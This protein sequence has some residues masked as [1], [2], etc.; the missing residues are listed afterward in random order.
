MSLSRVVIV[1]GFAVFFSAIPDASCAVFLRARPSK[2]PL[3]KTLPTANTSSTPPD[4]VESGNSNKKQSELEAAD[5]LSNDPFASNLVGQ[6]DDFAEDN[7]AERGA[8]NKQVENAPHGKAQRYSEPEIEKQPPRRGTYNYITGEFKPT[9]AA[10]IQ[11]HE[12][13]SDDNV[14][15]YT[16]ESWV[17]SAKY[18]DDDDDD[19]D[20][21][22]DDDNSE[23]EEDA[24]EDEADDEIKL[25]TAQVATLGK[26]KVV[27]DEFADDGSD[28]AR[29][30]KVRESTDHTIKDDAEDSENGEDSSARDERYLQQLSATLDS[31]DHMKPW[32]E[33]EK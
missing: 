13:I 21:D 22:D 16:G 18:D 28:G 32:S 14:M 8:L 4:A 33:L 31:M 10:L 17:D 20:E 1:L 29:I 19:S 9:G 30:E 26:N 5:A 2:E 3:N 6:V 15:G 23:G 25:S 27:D 12:Q 7:E 11:T 24:Y